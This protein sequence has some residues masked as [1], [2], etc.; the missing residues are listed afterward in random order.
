MKPLQRIDSAVEITSIV[1]DLSTSFHP[2]PRAQQHRQAKMVQWCVAHGAVHPAGA[3]ARGVCPESLPRA[4]PCPLHCALFHAAPA[5]APRPPSAPAAP[6]AVTHAL[7]ARSA[8]FRPPLLRAAALSLR[9]RA[10]R[11]CAL[12]PSR[13]LSPRPR[14]TPPP[15]QVRLLLRC[16][17]HPQLPCRSRATSR[18]SLPSDEEPDVRRSGHCGDLHQ[19]DIWR[20]S[21]RAA[22]DVGCSA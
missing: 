14:P 4:A 10:D 19:A 15:L 6:R 5:P 22:V 11:C 1:L 3:L 12:T 7:L 8:L 13:T 2:G 16:P 9:A 21:D 18:G 17:C 20:H